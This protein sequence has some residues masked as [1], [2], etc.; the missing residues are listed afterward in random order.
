VTPPPKPAARPRPAATPPKW[1]PDA[2]FLKPN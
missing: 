2:L 1:D